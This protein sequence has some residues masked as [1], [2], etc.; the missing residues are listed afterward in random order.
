MRAHVL[1]YIHRTGNLSIH[2]YKPVDE[3][4]LDPLVRPAILAN[5]AA[6]ISASLLTQSSNVLTVSQQ[7]RRIQSNFILA[8]NATN[9]A[10]SR[11]PY[12]YNIALATS[13]TLTDSR[14]P[15]HP[16]KALAYARAAVVGGN[17]LWYH[18]LSTANGCLSSHAQRAPDREGSL[19]PVG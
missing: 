16:R 19:G 11:S 2:C 13:G 6:H 9:I 4:L 12:S 1:S 3:K 17:F 14:S 10:A 5:V 7:H 18:M 8:H 15:Y